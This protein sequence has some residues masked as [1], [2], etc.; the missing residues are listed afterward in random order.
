MG[1]TLPLK[2]ALPD[3]LSIQLLASDVYA[4]FFKCAEGEEKEVWANMLQ[5][6]LGH[7]KFVAMMMEEKNVPDIVLPVVKTEVFRDLCLRARTYATESAFER[8]LWALRLE[9]A[10]I[11]FGVEAL[12]VRS[13]GD[14][15]NTPVYPGPVESHYADLLKWAARYRG[16][17]EISVQIARI[18]EHLPHKN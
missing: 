6:E 15:P 5:Q 2:E 4:T 13:I 1:E 18:E 14:A 12:A 16:A 11:D 9:H 10:Q 7:V 3:L 17:R 8:T